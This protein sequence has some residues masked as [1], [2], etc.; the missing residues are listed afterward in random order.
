[1]E[2]YGANGTLFAGL[3]PPSYELYVRN[4]IGD[5]QPGWHEW[6]A[7]KKPGID[8]AYTGEMARMLARVR[9]WDIDNEQWLDDANAVTTILD[10]I[11]SSAQADPVMPA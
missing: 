10:R 9:S 11:F 5:Y 1:M 4:A 2:F 8:P 3:E 7:L 6:Q